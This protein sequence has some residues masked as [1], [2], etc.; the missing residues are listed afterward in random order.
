MAFQHAGE[1]LFKSDIT[2]ERAEA[3]VP[4]L[5][6]VFTEKTIAIPIIVQ[7]PIQQV[8]FGFRPFKL[9]GLD[10][11]RYQPSKSE[12]VI[13]TLRTEKQSLIVQGAEEGFEQSPE[14]TLVARLIDIE[15]VDY[16]AHA[17][18]LYDLAGQVTT[19]LRSYLASEGEV[20]DVMQSHGK[21]IAAAIF[22]QMQQNMWAHRNWL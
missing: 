16:E 5:C 17:E 4:E 22:A 6:K 8:A 1:G 3:L 12:L 15:E 19:R 7:T 20:R 9:T 10:S 13:Q 11:W 14:D 2:V 21:A 18:L